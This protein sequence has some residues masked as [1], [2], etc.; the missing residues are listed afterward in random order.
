MIGCEYEE[1][2]VTFRICISYSYH[3]HF[4]KHELNG[5]FSETGIKSLNVFSPFSVLDVTRF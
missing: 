3:V 5:S 1:P 4:M 2:M